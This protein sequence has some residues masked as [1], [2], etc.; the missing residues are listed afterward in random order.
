TASRL[1]TGATLG[2]YKILA[3]LGEG[4]MGKVYKAR[5]T[6]LGR[7]VAIKVLN[8]RSS[9]LEREARAASALNHPNIVTVHD[10]A[11]TDGLDYL[12]MEYIPGNSLATR[13][14]PAGLP[15]AEAIACSVQIASALSAAHAANI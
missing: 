7:T 1:T 2:P 13:I 3:L 4:G 15:L 8:E 10:I 11:K 5:D 6:R 14:P 9:R 12:L